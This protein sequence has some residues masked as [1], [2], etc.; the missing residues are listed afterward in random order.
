MLKYFF[1]YT[2]LLLRFEAIDEKKLSE[3]GCFTKDSL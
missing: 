2:G 3:T 1:T